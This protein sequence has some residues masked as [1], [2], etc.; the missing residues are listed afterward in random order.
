[1]R[2]ERQRG[3]PEGL[4]EALRLLD[5]TLTTEPEGEPTAEYAV[6]L[7]RR[8]AIML[9]LDEHDESAFERAWADLDRALQILSDGYHTQTGLLAETYSLMGR[10]LYARRRYEE[11]VRYLEQALSMDARLG[12]AN[13]DLARALWLLDREGEALPY[14]T[15]SLEYNPTDDF[16]WYVRG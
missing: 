11:C 8:A 2:A 4:A 5:E 15:R 1:Y 3:D 6:A 7:I 12:A 10:W 14:A 16:L 13:G 9:Q